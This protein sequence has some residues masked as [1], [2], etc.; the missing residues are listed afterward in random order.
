MSSPPTCRP[1]TRSDQAALRK[2]CEARDPSQRERFVAELSDKACSWVVG[3]V[4]GAIVA[5][6]SL[7]LERD[8]RLGKVLTLCARGSEWERRGHLQG[9]LAALLDQIR[10]SDAA[11]IVYSTTRTLAIE[12]Q[13][14]TVDAGFKALGVFPGA[15]SADGGSV[16]GLTAWFAE[17]VIKTLR[18]A[19]FALH[20]AIAP[21]YA[22]AGEACGLPPAPKTDAAASAA[23]KSLSAYPD[24][25]PP[26]E[27]IDAARFAA[28]RFR[29]L[30]VRRG[31]SVNFY[32]FSEPN[33]VILS[34]DEGVQVFASLQPELGFATLIGEHLRSSVHP[35]RLYREAVRL[36]EAKGAAYVEAINDAADAASIECI[37]RAGFSPCGYFPCLKLSAARRRDF[38]VFAHSRARSIAHA[39]A[40][41]LHLR[42]LAEYLKAVDRGWPPGPAPPARAAPPDRRKEQG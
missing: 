26:L 28:E 1:A 2:L 27:L 37:L 18:H 10:S 23:E 7:K 3:L 16:S 21:F 4:D 35:V 24:V 15:R 13:L 39:A 19:D 33:V 40:H 20:P 14:A 9:V 29:R 12:E 36:L 41:P 6:G 17:G 42:F 22:L 11:D 38:V 32:P 5:A 8:T 30:K 31:L 25:L 34:A